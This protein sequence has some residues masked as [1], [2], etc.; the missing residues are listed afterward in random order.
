VATVGAGRTEVVSRIVDDATREVMASVDVTSL[1]LLGGVVHITGLRW[2]AV[3][4]S[5][6]EE[7]NE[8]T[9]SFAGLTV[10][11]TAVP[12]PGGSA[13]AAAALAPINALLLG[14]GLSI[15]PPVLNTAGGAADVSPLRIRLDHSPLGQAV[16]APVVTAAQPLREPLI[17]FYSGQVSC[18]SPIGSQEYPGKL[19]RAVV[20]PS[21]IALSSLTGTGGFV[22]ELGGVRAVTE[23]QTFANPFEGGTLAPGLGGGVGDGLPSFDGGGVPGSVGTFSGD[24]VS[25][26]SAGGAAP[27]ATVLAGRTLADSVPGGKGGAAATVGV[28]A[29][30]AILAVAVADYAR[31]Q[32][33]QRIIPEVE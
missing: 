1:D 7:T 15:D 30:L 20:L 2:R 11:G 6:K 26:G 3:Q 9:F 22:I 18:E 19:G 33:G 10:N 24:A 14:T 28:L 4:R 8:G 23:G 31:M 5:G 32:R 29:V 27:E 12:V 17:D 16:V 13:E 25:G 21:D